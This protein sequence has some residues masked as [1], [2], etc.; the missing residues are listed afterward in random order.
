MMDAIRSGT[1]AARLRKVT[2]TVRVHFCGARG[3]EVWL[4]SRDTLACEQEPW[5]GHMGVGW[6]RA[7]VAVSLTCT[8]QSGR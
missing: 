1:G 8:D 4:R 5:G 2:A 7:G 6:E 3:M